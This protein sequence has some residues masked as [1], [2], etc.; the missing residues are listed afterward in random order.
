MPEMG[1]LGA[2]FE[3]GFV[4]AFGKDKGNE[5]LAV[6]FAIPVTSKYSLQGRYGLLALNWSWSL[7]L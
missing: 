5:R 4:Y 3:I 1:N 2:L 6:L 7:V